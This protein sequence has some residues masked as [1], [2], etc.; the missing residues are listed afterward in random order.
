MEKLSCE[1]IKVLA[2]TASLWIRV[3]KFLAKMVILG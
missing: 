1:E 3:E 2:E